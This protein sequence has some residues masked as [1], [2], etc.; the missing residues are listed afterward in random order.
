MGLNTITN[1]NTDGNRTIQL[2][3]D[4]PEG[5]VRYFDH[6]RLDSASNLDIHVKLTFPNQKLNYHNM[7]INL[8]QMNDFLNEDE[9]YKQHINDLPYDEFECY[10][11]MGGLETA[12]YTHNK[13]RPIHFHK[14]CY[15]ELADQI[16]GFLKENIIAVQSEGG[17]RNLK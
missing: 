15:H 17:R 1:P 12:L 7:F 8:E 11:C 3:K 2:I 4:T 6:E 14:D 16:E 13:T 9:L 10:I 5:V